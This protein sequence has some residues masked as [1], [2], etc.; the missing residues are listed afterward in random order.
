[1]G[2]LSG[3]G[4]AAVGAFLFYPASLAM[5]YGFFLAALFVLAAGLSILETS[6]NPFAIAMGPEENA[7]KRLNLAQAF[8]PL[9]TNLGVLLAIF[10]IYP[11]LNPATAEQRAAMPPEWLRR[12]SARRSS[13]PSWGPISGWP[14]RW[15]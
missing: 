9:G 7:T 1:M 12:D 15:P 4:L 8:N 14:W 11:Y 13:M 3:L 6:A 10:L 5:T 2:V